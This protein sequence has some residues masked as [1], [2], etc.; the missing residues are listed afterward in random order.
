FLDAKGSPG[1]TQRGWVLPPASRIGPA[2][3]A[4]R[5]A[6][7]SQSQFGGKYDKSVDRESAFEVLAKRTDEKNTEQGSAKSAAGAQDDGIL[8]MVK[9]L[10]IGSTG[11]RGGRR[12]GV[13]QQV[14][15][16]YVRGAARQLIRGVLGSLV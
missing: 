8:G 11:P 10:M 7:R 9:D 13:V 14:A 3:D 5:Q 2:T 1:I 4:E 15:K 6:L 16:S 12:D